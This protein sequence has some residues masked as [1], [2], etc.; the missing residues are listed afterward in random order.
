VFERFERGR[1]PRLTQVRGSGIG[2]ALVKHIAEAHGGRAWVRDASPAGCRFSITL[3]AEL[4]VPK[5]A[6]GAHQTEAPA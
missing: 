3:S 1:G 5:A 4:K 6:A 2:L